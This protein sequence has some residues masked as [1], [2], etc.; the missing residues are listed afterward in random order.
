MLRELMCLPEST[1]WRK[2]LPVSGETMTL[3]AANGHL[4]VEEWLVEEYGDDPAVDIFS[5][6]NEE[7]GQRTSPFAMDAAGRNGHLAV[8]KYL[9]ELEISRSLGSK[10]RKRSELST[11]EEVQFLATPVCTESAMDDAADKGHLETLQWLHQNRTDGCTSLVWDLAAAS[12][13]LEVLKWLYEHGLDACTALTME[14]AAE[15]GKL[16]VLQWLHAN[17]SA[18][19]TTDTMD[20][21]ARNGHLGVVKWLHAHRAGGCTTDAMDGASAWGALAVVKWLHYNRTEGCTPQALHDAVQ[22]GH[23]DV[24]RWLLTH[25]VQCKS[26]SEKLLCDAAAF[27]RLEI[28]LFLHD[29]CGAR[30]TEEV[31]VAAVEQDSVDVLQW[32][33]G[34]YPALAAAVANR[35]NPF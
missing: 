29:A 16:G 35:T 28:F 31:A 6:G 22:G 25:S 30:C 3:A 12:G 14:L 18:C 34:H 15:S 8:V 4:D 27:N 13:H 32:I 1:T 19:C 9:H 20:A 7:E 17:T 10:K 5:P 24:V 21:A 33:Y 26:G 11:M 2:V 23:L